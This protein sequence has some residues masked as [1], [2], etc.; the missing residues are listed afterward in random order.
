M[1]IEQIT[2]AHLADRVDE[3]GDCMEWKLHMC[4]GKHPQWR[5]DGVCHPARRVVWELVNGP[6]RPGLQIGTTCGNP[7]CVNPAH[8]AARTRSKANKSARR[9]LIRK[10][11]ATATRRARSRL[12]PEI[13][14]EIRC[15]DLPATHFDRKYGL[16]TGYAWRI[17]K[18]LAWRDI[19]SHFAGLG[20][21]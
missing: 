15:S 19:T 2:L 17:R 6:V 14:Q 5:V 18:G 4:D 16:S 10:I 20:D 7:K 8:L 1:K 11:R 13:A 9:S 3:V 21:R 12:T